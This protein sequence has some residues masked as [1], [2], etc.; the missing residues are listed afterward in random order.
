M[1]VL[2][3]QRMSIVALKKERKPILEFLQRC[4]VL[5]VEDIPVPD[6]IFS[7]METTSSRS[8]FEKNIAALNQGLEL[9]S[10]YAPAKT[11]LLSMLDGR[12]TLSV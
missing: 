5:E 4:G 9:L 6:S 8:V 2:P 7:K 1:A 12:K 11:G 3:M 10:Q